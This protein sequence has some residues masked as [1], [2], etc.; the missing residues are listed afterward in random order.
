MTSVDQLREIGR[1]PTPLITV[2]A[3]SGI[4][5]TTERTFSGMEL[6]SGR[7]STS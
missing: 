5:P 3:A 7:R 6:P 2:A 1:G 4:S